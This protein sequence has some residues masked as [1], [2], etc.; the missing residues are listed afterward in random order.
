MIQLG[1]AQDTVRYDV[2]IDRGTFEIMNVSKMMY[3]FSLWMRS[4]PC[5]DQAIK[6]AK[7]KVHVYSV[8][9]LCLGKMHDHSE[10]SEKWKSQITEFQQSIE[11]AELSGID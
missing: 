3:T 11:Y 9:A 8:S 4:T 1:G 5:H 6:H 7:A 10:S 2:E